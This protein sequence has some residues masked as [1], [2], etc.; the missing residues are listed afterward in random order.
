[1]RN[2]KALSHKVLRDLYTQ[3]WYL[4]LRRRERKRWRLGGRH[5]LWI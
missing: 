1:M 4:P 5:G 3:W 2:S